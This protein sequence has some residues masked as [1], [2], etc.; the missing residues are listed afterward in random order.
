MQGQTNDPDSPPY[1]PLSEDDEP[2]R[3]ASKR[4]S[5]YSPVTPAASDDDEQPELKRLRQHENDTTAANSES[6][7]PL[8]P[9][10]HVKAKATPDDR[11]MA[12]VAARL[13]T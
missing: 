4:S 10:H 8:T 2:G 9:D 5:E 13:A 7:S 3:P 1:S 6:F 12:K 11:F